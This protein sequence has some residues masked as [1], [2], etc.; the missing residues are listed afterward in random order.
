MKS[1]FEK[2]RVLAIIPVY[3][4]VGKIGNVIS[5]FSGALA[6]EIFLIIDY[7]S[8]LIVNEIERAKKTID[9]S[10]K[11]FKNRQRKGVGYAIRLG[12]SYAISHDFDIIVVMAGNDKDDPKEIPR[13]LNEIINNNSDYVQG[14]R[15]LP[16]GY[17]NGIPLLR[18]IFVRL[19]PFVW[20]ILTKYPCTDV[21]NGFRAYRTS[22]FED[23]RI[24]IMQSWLDSYEL[25]YYIHYKMIK[26]GYKVKEVPVSK[27]YPEDRRNGYTKIH[28]LND[29]W[30][31]LRPLFYLS[32][33]LRK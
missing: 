9:V 10:V 23:K 2:H 16:S 19:Y 12:I 20:S 5:R 22:I 7:P 21:T 18:K 1:E 24:N 32:L 14:S 13:F 17:H 30:R 11:T 33:G 28:P 4:E 8:Q 15:F 31:I 29:S 25:E 27:I 6:D 3:N 26:L